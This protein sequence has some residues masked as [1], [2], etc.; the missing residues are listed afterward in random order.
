MIIEKLLKQENYNQSQLAESLGV[1]ISLISKLRHKHRNFS[2]ELAYKI[3][4]KYPYI[5]FK[6]LLNRSNANEKR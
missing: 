1:S 6:E 5:D 4:K 2:V 3:N